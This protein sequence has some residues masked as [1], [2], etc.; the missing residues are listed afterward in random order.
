MATIAPGSFDA[1]GPDRLSGTPRAHV[2]DRWIYVFTVASFIA[3][4]LVG[5]V[6][7]SLDKIAA[8]E[9]GARP[10]FPLVMHLHA[11]LMASYLAL[12]LMQTSLAAT[13]RLHWHRKLGVLAAIIVPVLVVVGLILAQAMYRESWMA[14]QAVPPSARGKLEAVL[15]RKENILLVQIRMSLLFPLFVA[16]GLLARRS[17]AG[18]HKRMMMLAT[19]VVLPPA[20]NRIGWLPSTFPNSFVTTELYMLLAISPMFV[21]DV[22]R[23]GFVHKAYLIWAGVSLPFVIALNSLWNAPSWHAIARTL[24]AP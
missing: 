16:I 4:V 22:V 21:W 15:F 3:I 12:Q 7:D 20:I 14:A 5:F 6:P 19:V 8:V 9:A 17:D 18:L 23:N 11:G 10:P 1:S 13:D 24:L 2:V